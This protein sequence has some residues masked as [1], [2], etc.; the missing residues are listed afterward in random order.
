[1]NGYD[2]D[3]LLI[4]GVM[5]TVSPDGVVN[6]APMGPIVDAESQR[7][8]FRP[9]KTSTTYRNLKASGAGVFHVI[10][11]VLLI[12]RA[13]I[14]RVEARFVAM[15]SG[16]E[17][18]GVEMDR[19]G[20]RTFRVDGFAAARV[21]GL[22]LCG[23]SRW[24]ELSVTTLDDSEER[25]S[26]EAVCVHVGRGRDL[27][28]F[29]R[30]KNAV[31]EAAIL[32]TRLHLTGKPVVLAELARLQIPVDKTGSDAEHRAFGEVRAYIEAWRDGSPVV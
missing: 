26:I 22:V 19:I 29:N 4:E 24:H 5:T 31:I 16:T 18:R 23:A 10:D 8:L 28:G 17:S 13:A 14:G 12:A 32:A 7:F 21:A 1:M 11:D 2:K 6:V 20:E 25:T 3:S 30:A 15:P 27:A 9:F